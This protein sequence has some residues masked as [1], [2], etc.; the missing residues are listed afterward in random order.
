VPTRTSHRVAV[1]QD[2]GPKDGTN[3]LHF[4]LSILSCFLLSLFHMFGP[5]DPH[6]PECAFAY[7]LHINRPRGV[8]ERRS[9]LPYSDRNEEDPRKRLHREL[10]IGHP[11]EHRVESMGIRGPD[12]RVLDAAKFRF[13]ETTRVRVRDFRFCGLRSTISF[14]PSHSSLGLSLAIVTRL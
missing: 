14:T 5:Q 6:S 9:P 3:C 1:M 8:A 4:T 2:I 11:A 7:E 10:P 12:R 13:E